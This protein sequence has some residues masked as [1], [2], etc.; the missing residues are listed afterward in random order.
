M[1]GDSLAIALIN[2]GEVSTSDFVV[3]AQGVSLTQEGR[4]ATIRGY[5]R[6]L[7]SEVTHPIFGY[8]VTYRRVLEVQARLLAAH[9][10]GE[11]PS[12]TAFKTR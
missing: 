4:K 11:I 7:D 6:R 10:M 1:L 5:E 2:N 12:Y 3:R 9:L 8:K